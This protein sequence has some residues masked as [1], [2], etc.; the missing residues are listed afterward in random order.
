MST[1]IFDIILNHNPKEKKKKKIYTYSDK[2]GIIDIYSREL[3]FH[4]IF[5][6]DKVLSANQIS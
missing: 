4:Y 6:F 3:K 2:Y 1:F 5:R